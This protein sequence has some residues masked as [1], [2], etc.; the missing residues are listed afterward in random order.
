MHSSEWVSRKKRTFTPSNQYG[1][2]ESLQRMK[3][4]NTPRFGKNTL[5]STP[6][7]KNVYQIQL[8]E[9]KL[10]NEMGR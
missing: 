10:T 9:K 6:S 1:G 8:I 5:V 4:E 3:Q 2:F 7:P